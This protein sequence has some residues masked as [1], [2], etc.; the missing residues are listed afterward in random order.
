MLPKYGS[1][2]EYRVKGGEK[3]FEHV[4]YY[5]KSLPMGQRLGSSYQ[6]HYT[7]DMGATKSIP[8]CSGVI[9]ASL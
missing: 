9:T 8:N 7:S 4:V 3:Y 2:D 1:Y 5:P 6:K